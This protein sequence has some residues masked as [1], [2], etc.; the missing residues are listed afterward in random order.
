MTTHQSKIEKLIAELCPNGVEFKELGNITESIKTGLNPRQNFSLNTL[1]AKNF[2][3]TV[4]EITTGKVRFSDK[5][6]KINDDALKIIKNRSNLAIGDVLFSGIGTIGKVALV[7]IPT[8]N[9]NCSESVFIIKPKQE[10]ILSKFLMYI[11]GSDVVKNQY[12]GQTVGSTLKGVRMATLASIKIPLPP[13]AIQE[14]IVKILD[15]FTELEAEL[16]ARKKQGRSNIDIIIRNYCLKAK[17]QN[18]LRLMK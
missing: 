5:T 16:E 14:E 4:K 9:W 1:D 7:D 17:N 11:L 2:Y 15:N 18:I 13:L 8:N 3:V 12:R 6:D 10:I